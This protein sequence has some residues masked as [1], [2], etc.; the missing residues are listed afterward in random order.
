MK[1][2]EDFDL[3]RLI[4]LGAF[5][6][7]LTGYFVAEARANLGR[8]FRYAMAWVFIFLGAILGVAVW[9][10]VRNVVAPSQAV[11]SGG[12]LEVPR[13]PD[14]HF[15]LVAQLNGTPV[16]FLVDTGASDIVLS[17]A[18]AARVGLPDDLP[19]LGTAQ[20]A[21]GTVRLAFA[22]IDEM[23]VGESVLRDVPVSVN[24]GELFKSLLGMS[25]LGQYGRIEIAGDRLL[26]EP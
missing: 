2:M 7:L 5:L 10:D 25:W 14:G 13:G 9:E 12:A 16:D 21:N 8:T 6:L 17:R 15:H 1:G 26:L 11:L 24:E 19:F 4:Y 23:R 22:R 20:T 18:D 3:G